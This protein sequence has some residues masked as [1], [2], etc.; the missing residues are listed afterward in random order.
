MSKP[1][2]V[3]AAALAIGDELLSG[4]TKDRNI[5]Y[6]ADYLTAMGIDLK[7]ARIVGD[8]Q[9]AIVDA[10]NALRSRHT[11]LFTCGGIGPTHD[12]ITA[13]AIG[14]AFGVPVGEHGPT[15]VAMAAEYEA[16]GIEFTAA[17]RRMA[18]L[19]QGAEP[20][21]NPVSK[22]P[23]FRV[24]NVFVLAGIPAVF[25]AML[26]SLAPTLDTGARTLSRSIT[27]PHPEGTIGERLGAI[28]ADQPDVAIGSYPQFDGKRFSTQI[29][30]RGRDPANLDAAQAAVEGML[31]DLGD[32]K[33]PG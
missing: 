6:L 21:E 22:A 17:R 4:R 30:L 32:T 25:Q 26:E 15:A 24:D 16:R 23:G 7:E 14:A 28:Q 2:I 19:P 12:D 31:A 8:D 3:T 11:Y 1:K 13:D 5:A 18:R 9:D 29:V 33:T 20:I 27:C 10:V